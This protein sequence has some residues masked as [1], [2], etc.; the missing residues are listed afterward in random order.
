MAGLLSDSRTFCL[1]D[2]PT[3]VTFANQTPH[4]AGRLDRY[5]KLP[6][7]QKA[8]EMLELV[9]VIAESLKDGDGKEHFVREMMTN[10]YVIQVKIAGAEGGS[11][12]FAQD[13]KCGYH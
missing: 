12:L 1:P 6:I 8:E 5:R 10:A 2:F 7:F 11:P 9:E 3:I 13:A 4:M